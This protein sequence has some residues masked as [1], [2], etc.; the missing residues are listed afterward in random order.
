MTYIPSDDD[1]YVLEKA[2]HKFGLKNSIR[3]L[4]DIYETSNGETHL[5]NINMKF[6]TMLEST[7]NE[8]FYPSSHSNQVV[9]DSGRNYNHL[10]ELDTSTP[11]VVNDSGRTYNHLGE[12]VNPNETFPTYTKAQKSFNMNELRGGRSR[13]NRRRK[14]K[15]RR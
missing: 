3:M 15:T 5:N 13:K 12:L 14:H 9:N 2:F 4:T 11:Q 6:G 7:F 8:V 1:I 10:G